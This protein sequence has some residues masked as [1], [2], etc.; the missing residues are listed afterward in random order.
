MS[1]MGRLAWVALMLCLVEQAF[2]LPVATR[3][4]RSEDAV[5]SDQGRRSASA[6][7]AKPGSSIIEVAEFSA[8][9][10]MPPEVLAP[11]PREPPPDVPQPSTK[12][13]PSET[14]LP[15]PPSPPPRMPPLLQ[16]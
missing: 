16:K 7:L 12:T 4:H 3:A 15:V 1:M 11:P 9:P 13:A 5:L 8:S 2:S 6:E 14:P 10:R